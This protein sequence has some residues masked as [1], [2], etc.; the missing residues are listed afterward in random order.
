LIDEI[1]TGQIP[2]GTVLEEAQIGERFKASR[3][4]YGRPLRQL[5]PRGWLRSV[6]VEVL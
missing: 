6:R 2:P 1:T 3:T 4:L 5:T